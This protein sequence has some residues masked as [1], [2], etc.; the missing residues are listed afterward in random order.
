MAKKQHVTYLL[1][2]V[3]MTAGIERKCDVSVSLE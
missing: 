2:T 3:V 1:L